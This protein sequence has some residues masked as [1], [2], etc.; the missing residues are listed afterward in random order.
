MTEKKIPRPRMN[1]LQQF[2]RGLYGWR[3]AAAIGA[4]VGAI[5]LALYPIAVKPYLQTSEWKQIQTDNRE[6]MGVA[7]EDRQPGNMK[8]WGDPFDRK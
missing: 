5:G 7:R 4:L 1:E 6:K 3:F 2:H 8:V